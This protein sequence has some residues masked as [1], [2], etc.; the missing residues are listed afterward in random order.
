MFLQRDIPWQLHMLQWHDSW[1]RICFET[2]LL[3]FN[4]LRPWHLDQEISIFNLQSHLHEESRQNVHDAKD[5]QQYLGVHC[6]LFVQSATLPFQGEIKRCVLIVV[7][8][9]ARHFQDIH[10]LQAYKPRCIEKE[11]WKVEV[12]HVHE[13]LGN[14]IPTSQHDESINVH[15]EVFLLDWTKYSYWSK[16]KAP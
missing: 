13:W 1:R 8:D 14:L 15:R 6:S 5:N 9:T 10:P 3:N 4:A 7:V 2:I 12:G 16:S 11:G